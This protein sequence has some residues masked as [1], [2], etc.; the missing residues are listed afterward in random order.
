MIVSVENLRCLD[1]LVWLRTGENAA[2]KLE[3]DQATICRTARKVAKVLEVEV[4]KLDGEWQILGDRSLLD[5]ERQSHQ[6]FRWQMEQ[7]LRV[8]AQYYSGPLFLDPRPPGWLPGNFDFL[9]VNTP[10]QLLRS[11]VI[12]AWI[13]CHP[14]VPDADDEELACFDLTRLPT[15][16]VVSDAHPLLQLGDAIQLEDVLRYPSLALPDGAFPKVQAALRALGLWTSTTESRRY[17]YELWEGKTADELTVGYASAFTI[18]LFERPQVILPVPI[19]LEVG[20]TLVVRRDFCDH[21]RLQA[22]VSELRW[23][24]AQLA[25]QYPEVRLA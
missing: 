16:L 10:L 19:E 11:R 3:V 2:R 9:E 20:D 17:D 4:E 14:D 8:E 6:L 24:A 22:L 5:L 15:W 21:P 12:D 7:L 25:K 13:A 18:G 23:R 1:C